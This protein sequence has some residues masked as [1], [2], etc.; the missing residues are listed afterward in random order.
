[1][2]PTGAREVVFSYEPDSFRYGLLIS[3]AAAALWLGLAW[4]GRRLILPP[5]ANMPADAGAQ[6]KV[7]AAL[8]A[9]VF[10]LHGIATQ[11]PLWSGWLERLRLGVGS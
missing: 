9:L 8:G 1:M 10:V 2:V 3:V 11:V 6:W 4:G 7:R 5:V